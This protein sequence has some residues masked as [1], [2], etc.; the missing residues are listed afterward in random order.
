MRKAILPL[1]LRVGLS[2][3]N[4]LNMS[5]RIDSTIQ[6]VIFLL[7]GNNQQLTAHTVVREKSHT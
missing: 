2:H 6:T 1:C 5:A 4:G 3:A 7:P